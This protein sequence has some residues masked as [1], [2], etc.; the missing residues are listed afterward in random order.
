MDLSQ[1]WKIIGDACAGASDDEDFLGRIDS[2]LRALKPEELLEFETHFNKMNA[3]AYS[4]NL[5]GAA[6]LMNGGCSD[7][8]FDYFRAWLI[9]QGQE[10]FET[11]LEDPDSLAAL[12][13][14][15]GELEEL[16][17]LA[18]EAYEEKTGEE[19]PDSVFE[20][21]EQPDLGQGWDFDDKTEMKK[22]YPRLFVKYG[23]G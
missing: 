20:G 4:W 7:D 16:I 11:A 1:F 13:D 22:R 6:Y 14:P 8:G 19:M 17:Y 12:A 2:Y 23:G 15:E 9:A 18:G 3:Q 5:W 21:A 10:T